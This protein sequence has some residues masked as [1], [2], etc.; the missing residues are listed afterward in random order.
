MK[1]QYTTCGQFGLHGKSVLQI[2]VSRSP[3][4]GG[5]PKKGPFKDKQK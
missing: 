1:I 2:N 5:V 4:I 3:G